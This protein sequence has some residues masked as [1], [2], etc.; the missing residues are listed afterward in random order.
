MFGASFL[1]AA[2]ILGR[3]QLEMGSVNVENGAWGVPFHKDWTALSR[4]TF[5]RGRLEL[6]GVRPQ[7]GSL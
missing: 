3:I 4:C 6:D 7:E 2:P 5:D 1:G